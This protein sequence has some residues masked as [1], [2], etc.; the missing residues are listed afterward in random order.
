MIIIKNKRAIE[1]MRQAG[2]LLAQVFDSIAP[3]VKAGAS[4]LAIEELIVAELARRELKAES[5][6]YRG[7]RHNS[8]ISINDEVVHGVPHEDKILHDGDLVSIDICASWHGYCADMTRS[9]LIGT[10]SKKLQHFVYTAQAAL[11]LGIAQARVGTHLSD[12]SSAIARE[13]ERNGYSVVRDFAGHGIGKTMHEDPEVLNYG[14]PGEGPVLCAGMT[15]A[16]EPMIAMGSYEV[17]VADDGWT[18]KTKDKS[19]AAHIEDTVLIT[20]EGPEI[21]TRAQRGQYEKR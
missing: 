10:P 20:E 11:D 21:L 9:Y 3:S 17:F 5:L 8:C 13:V 6:G 18:V 14:K 4:T 15:L 1:T 7:Y 2:M 19:F 12:I 16:I